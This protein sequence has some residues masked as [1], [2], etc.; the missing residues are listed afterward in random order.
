MEEKSIVLSPEG[1]IDSTNCMQLESAIAE[2]VRSR[3]DAPVILDFDRLEYISSAGLRVLLKASKG[4]QQPLSIR[5]APPEI[6]DILD[7]TGFTA[8]LS[9]ERRLRAMSVD[10]CEV[11]GRGAMGTVYRTDPDTIV[12]VY[13]SPDALDM[14]RQEQRRAKQAFLKGV[15]TAISYDAV[16][17]GDRYGSVFELVNAKTFN[18]L[19]AADV[20][21][22]AILRQYAGVIRQVHGI[23]A[24]PG[25]LPDCREVYIGYLD[26]IRQ[27][28]PAE[29]AER[30]KALLRA[31]PEDLHLIHGDFHMKN[32]M[33]SNGEPLLI[34][35]DTLSVGN[36]VFD[37]AGLFVAYQAFSEDEPDNSMDFMGIP[38]EVSLGLWKKVLRY[39]RGEPDEEAL[40]RAIDR[41]ELVGC[42]R[43][44]YLLT[45][46]HLGNPEYHALRVR[47][48]VDRMEKLLAETDCLEL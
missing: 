27:A 9:V 35:M 31:L 16:R 46:V 10:G 13:D 30:M 24:E 21:N 45:V 41:T 22:D 12:K 2:A 19:F 15:P 8:I 42:V 1:R 17:V 20:E 34:D 48:A 44:L 14:I 4:M 18:D 36:P 5:N 26:A 43:F 37:F 33:L 23:E 40:R 39:Y 3:P 38:T 32:V 28:L 25:E 29:T 7:V 6:Y 11:I 47:H